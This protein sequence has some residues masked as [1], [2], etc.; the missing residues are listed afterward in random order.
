MNT[1]KLTAGFA[2]FGKTVSSS[3]TPFAARSQQWI[4]EQTGSASVQTELP[5][6]YVELETRIEALKQTHQKL[7]AAT[8]QYANEAYD[9]PPNI[10]E[11]FQDLAKGIG[12]KVNLL[13]KASSVSNAQEALTAPSSE[14]PQPKTF[15]HA[16]ARAA[17]AGSQQLTMATPQGSTEPDPL[18]QG[19]EKF[20]V[21]EEKVGHARLEQDEK[22]QGMFLAGWSTT[23]NQSIKSAGKA[24]TAVANARLS[25]DAA[26]AR[27]AAGGR[28][29]ENYTE[30][31]KRAI[32]QAED[33]FVEKVD[34]ATSVMRNVLDTPEPLRNVAALVQAQ[35]EFHA[36]SAEILEEV[37]KSID[38]IQMD[39]ETSYR[40]ARDAQ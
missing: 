4:R 31:Q 15:S 13:S 11:S 2:S 30:Q 8:S 24:R 26:K 34:E 35:A 39:Q 22:I 14:K 9:Y 21:A 32:E 33:V 19:L 38:E 18:A 37:A 3:V 25:L 12:E 27:A 6:D 28:H 16:I 1:E 20:A 23:L 40:R 10:R 5:H 36:R 29:E 17:L 7:L